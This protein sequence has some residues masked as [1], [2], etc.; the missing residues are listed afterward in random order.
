VRAIEALREDRRVLAVLVDVDSPCGSASVSDAIF[1]A[2]RRLSAKKP[3]I[4]FVGNAGLS[5]G[6][7]IACGAQ[8][9]V[10]LPTALSVTAAVL[11]TVALA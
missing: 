11:R 7:L 10:A 2:L 6:Y 3:T 4:A 1:R 5:G 9:I 8:R